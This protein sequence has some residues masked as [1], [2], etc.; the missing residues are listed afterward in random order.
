M[1]KLQEIFPVKHFQ[2][3]LFRRLTLVKRSLKSVIISIVGTLIFSL[4]AIVL[5]WLMIVL[6]NPKHR[7]PNFDIYY[8]SPKDLIYVGDTQNAFV[9][10]L[11]D[12]L[13]TLFKEDTG[14]EPTVTHFESSQIFNDQ[15][16][17]NLTEGRFVYSAPFVV[18]YQRTESPYQLLV[19]YNSTSVYSSEEEQIYYGVSNINRAL[20]KMQFGDD[21][22]FTFKFSKLQ[23][24][25]IQRIF[26]QLGPM[27]IACG[28]ISIVPLIISQPITDINGEVRQYMVSCTL[29]ILPYWVATFL[30]DIVIWVAITTI[31]W[32]IFN[33][34]MITSFHDNL[35]SSWYVLTFVGPS[36]LLF[37]YCFSFLFSSPDSAPRQA[38]M[39]LI[40]ILIIPV[41][42]VIIRDENNPEWLDWIYSLFPQ[43]SIQQLLGTILT[44]MG[45]QKKDFSF[46]WS[47]PSSRPYLVMQWVDIIIYIIV[48]TLIEM[49]RLSVQRKNAKKSFGDYHDFFKEAKSKHPVTPEAHQM[50]REV[51]ESTDYAVR[52]NEVSRL[53]INTAG[54]PIPAVNCVSLGVKEGSLFGFLGANGAGKTTLIRM[55][56]GMLPPSDGTIEI[57]GTKIEELTDPTILSICPQFNNHLCMEMTPREHFKLY[58][59][60]FQMNPKKTKE[61]TENLMK[62]LEL[63]ELGDKPIR[64]LSGGDVRK[65]AIALSFLGPAKIILLDEPTASLDPV[66]RHHV[67][68]M[69]L[70]YKGMKTF[71]LCTHLL[72]EAENL[73]DT[74]SIMIKGTVYT[75]GSPEYLTHK[76]GT[77]YK[78]DVM[79]DDDLQEDEE[80]CDNFFRDNLP[81]AVL[82]IKRPKARI[83]S[84]PASD[85]K[86]PALFRLMQKG[87]EGDY[88]F[89]YYTCSCSSLESVFM[90]IVRM[91]ESGDGEML[92]IGNNGMD[93]KKEDDDPNF[94]NNDKPKLKS[95][96]PPKNDVEHERGEISN[97]DSMESL[98]N[99]SNS[100]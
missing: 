54:E 12:K 96:S 32:A 1:G 21:K 57:M 88:G 67:H 86:L 68:D 26:G 38:F 62:I 49:F 9:K 59:L 39:I 52:I 50:E 75:V 19:L 60:L 18:D 27:L 85:I 71:M 89:S 70:E 58:S 31:I 46:Y 43:I 87:S 91:S 48:L 14:I 82:S 17:Q 23:R 92:N 2:A 3:I 90:E 74:I 94:N 8:N 25:L 79:L 93:E 61:S 15:L 53:F 100:V 77:E 11:Q 40:L 4:L 36:F 16:Y 73:C 78:V 84:I 63:E 45:N 28:L 7:I 83:Y 5:Q 69:I 29:K 66:A 13:K 64:E 76:F 35:F 30:I 41:I 72:S 55:I 37:I 6:M 56:T 80:K 20:W 34:A 44:F 22:S 24:R 97:S 51:H 81:S 95:N 47:Y 10:Q 65:L 99:D 42:V 98:Y 33:A